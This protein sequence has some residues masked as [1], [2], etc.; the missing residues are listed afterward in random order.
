MSCSGF[1]DLILL[2]LFALLGCCLNIFLGSSFPVHFQAFSTF[3]ASF[4]VCKVCV[5]VSS[6][7]GMRSPIQCVTIVV[8]ETVCI[9]SQVSL[10]L[11]NMLRRCR[12]YR[13]M[14]ALHELHS[15]YIRKEIFQDYGK[16]IF[17]LKIN[18]ACFMLISNIIDG[19]ITVN[20]LVVSWIC[21]MVRSALIV[22]D[23]TIG[24]V[25]HLPA[26]YVFH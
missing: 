7:L 21:F 23:T 20:P 24:I 18:T 2:V 10:L 25:L 12:Y 22:T 19:F 6:F 15:L 11:Y 13:C 14:V 4:L 3:K 26:P 8:A 9:R 1:W 5:A 16:N 17:S